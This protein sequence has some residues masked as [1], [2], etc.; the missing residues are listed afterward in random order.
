MEEEGGAEEVRR[1]GGGE[2]WKASV[3]D[4][5]YFSRNARIQEKHVGYSGCAPPYTQS[6]AR[7]RPA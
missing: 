7:R 1:E 2:G 3:V 4:G 6:S 5:H